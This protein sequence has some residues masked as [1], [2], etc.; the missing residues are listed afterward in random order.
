[1]ELLFGTNVREY[2]QHVG[3]LAG[4]ELDPT[5]HQVRKVI[6]STDGE[7]GNH[8]MMRRFESVLVEPREIEIRPYTPGDDERQAG[9]VM[10]GHAAHILRG[11][12]DLGRLS[13]LD[14]AIGTGTLE[15]VIGRRSWWTRR[16]RLGSAGLDLSMPGQVRVPAARSQAA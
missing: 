13:G 12:R 2:G 15:G 14:V 9:A 8:A 11:G 7:L 16:F 3:R 5:T 6:F 1:V 4:F 10:L